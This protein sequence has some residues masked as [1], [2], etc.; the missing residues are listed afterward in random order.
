MRILLL[1]LPAIAARSSAAAATVPPTCGKRLRLNS[2]LLVF[3]GLDATSSDVRS[4]ALIL[5]DG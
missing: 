4:F 3:G 1:C 5:G 2:E